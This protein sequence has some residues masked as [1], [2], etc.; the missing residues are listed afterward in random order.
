M[1]QASE[2]AG[3]RYP[4]F[5]DTRKA[6]DC[7]FS[8]D[9]LRLYWPLEDVFPSAISVFSDEQT[10]GELEPFFQ[11]VSD[12]SGSGT[13]H[14][15]AKLPIT[16]SKVSSIVAELHGLD[17]WEPDWVAWHECHDSA[18]FTTYGD[19]SD[20]DRPYAKEQKEDGSWEEDSDTEFLIRCCGEERPLYKR[21]PFRLKITPSFGND[22]VNIYD[23]VSAVHPWLMSLRDDF[24][25]YATVARPGYYVRSVHNTKWM[26]GEGPD[27][28]IFTEET[29]R[30]SI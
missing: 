3:P 25:R 5:K 10:P 8:D 4:S 9:A 22:F 12:G 24:L 26:I 11:P 18:E 27:H 16:T 29:W 20:E 30:R 28:E 19:L 7:A 23:Y 15:I 6:R 14:E 1:A 17:Q 13:W 2:P 21:G